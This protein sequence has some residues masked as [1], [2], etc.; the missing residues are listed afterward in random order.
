MESIAYYLSTMMEIYKRFVELRARDDAE[1]KWELVANRR[2][3]AEEIGRFDHFLL[4]AGARTLDPDIRREFGKRLSQLR[5]T[6][7]YHQASWPAVKI[8]EDP[9]GYRRTSQDAET[10]FR[11]FLGWGKQTLER[12]AN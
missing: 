7:T 11:D 2:H 9:E 4:G 3:L 1:R 6:I 8:D 12:S 10:A 5:G